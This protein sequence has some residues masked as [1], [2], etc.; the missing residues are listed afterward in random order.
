MQNT[1]GALRALFTYTITHTIPPQ[2]I[3]LGCGQGRKAT[4]L[5]S[6]CC[7]SERSLRRLFQRCILTTSYATCIMKKGVAW[8]WSH[9]GSRLKS[10]LRYV[11]VSLWPAPI[12]HC[13]AQWGQIKTGHAAKCTAKVTIYRLCWRTRCGV[14]VAANIELTMLMLVLELR[15]KTAAAAAAAPNVPVSYPRTMRS[16]ICAVNRHVEQT[17]RFE[18][19]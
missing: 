15:V 9:S 17:E 6:H 12:V 3:A 2:R 5:Q 13:R 16:L 1:G 8:W 14:G 11:C 7:H 4:E 19:A 18:Y 10:E